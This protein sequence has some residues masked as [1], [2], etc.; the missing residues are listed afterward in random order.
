MTDQPTS[1]PAVPLP[2]TLPYR[3]LSGTDDSAFCEKVST[4]LAQGY[5]L[6][7]DPAVTTGPDGTAL[8]VQAVVLAAAVDERGEL[9]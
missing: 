5:R 2:E 1:T 7:G 4:A 9:R 6:H 3:L 8:V